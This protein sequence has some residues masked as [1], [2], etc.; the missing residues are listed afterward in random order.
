MDGPNGCVTAGEGH[1]LSVKRFGNILVLLYVLSLAFFDKAAFLGYDS[2]WMWVGLGCVGYALASNNMQVT[3]KHIA[4]LDFAHG[5]LDAERFYVVP[6]SSVGGIIVFE[7][8]KSA[9]LEF[10][11][12][13][14]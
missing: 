13:S 7:P 6:P 10:G 5:A 11:V 3:R 8:A 9:A 1:E 4:A 14:A 2:P 12:H